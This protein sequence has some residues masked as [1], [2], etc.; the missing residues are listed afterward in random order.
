MQLS[1]WQKLSFSFFFFLFFWL[2]VI[3]LLCS[4]NHLCF[5]SPPN[6]SGFLLSELVCSH[7]GGS[8]QPFEVAEALGDSCPFYAKS[9]YIL[10]RF[11]I[12]SNTQKLSKMCGKCLKVPFE[13]SNIAHRCKVTH[14]T[15]FVWVWGQNLLIL[16]K[17]LPWG[18][19]SWG[20]EQGWSKGR[21]K[22]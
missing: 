22:T 11:L 15:S 3:V 21:V 8:D 9:I 16:H 2:S 14:T 18:L 17:E 5:V 19:W 4:W 13:I 12:I 6:V 1:F 10:V 20:N 7:L